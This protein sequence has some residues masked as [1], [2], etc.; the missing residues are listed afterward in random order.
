MFGDGLWLQRD[1]GKER[2][3]LSPWGWALRDQGKEGWMLSPWEWALASAGF[4]K[5]GMDA[6]SLG[7]GS[8][9][10][11][12]QERRDGCSLLG[13][14]L[15]LQRD[16]GKEGWMLSPWEWALAS[17]GFRKGGMD[18]LSLGMGSGFSGIQERRDGCS[19]LGNGLWLQ[20][21]SGKEGWMLSPWEWALASAGFRKGGMDALSLGMGSGFSGIQERR[22]GC[23]LL[24]NGLWLQR[25][26]GKEGW[27]LSP[28]EW[29]LAS[30]GF[31]KGGMDA[32]SLGMGS[33]FS[34]I[35]ERRDGCSLLGNG[36]WL[37]RDS[38]KEGWM[39]SP[40]EWAL[41][42]AGFRKGG[43][44]ASSLLRSATKWFIKP[45]P[46]RDGAV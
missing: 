9:F 12:I 8:G 27:M 38:G 20:R 13:N 21:D 11:G 5:G 30:A 29:A 14:G 45:N 19:L 46:F 25:D 36:L 43:M 23:S 39:L 15:W 31:R 40:W 33:G 42:S 44:D 26:S 41:A 6:L 28:W 18:A 3:M 2:W 32:L 16:S 1:Q 34:G 24:G 37:Q 35:Q 22:D 10:S 17:A 7:M 4:R